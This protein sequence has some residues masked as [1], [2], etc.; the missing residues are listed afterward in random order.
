MNNCKTRQLIK[1]TFIVIIFS[2]FLLTFLSC[3]HLC[4]NP[5][6]RE[7]IILTQ[8][9]GM[10]IV[11]YIYGDEYHHR[12]ETEEGYTIILNKQTGTI[13]YAKLENNR[14]VPSG[15]ITGAVAP[16]YLQAIDYPKH[17]S[18]RKFK[19]AEIRRT[20]PERLHDFIS[21]KRS[22][23]NAF[24]T[25]A[26][27]GT[28]KV[29]VVCVEFQPE[30]SPPTQWHSGNYSPSGF[31]RRIFSDDPSDI[32]MT[33]YYKSNSYNKFWPV[34]HTYPDWVTLPQTASWYELSGNWT[35]IIE[36]AMDAIRNIDPAYDFTQY[37]NDGDLDLILIW[38]GT[39]QTWGD[40]YWPHKSSPF[41]NR[42]GV[43]IKYYNAVN[44][45]YSSGT[46]NT[47]IAVFCHEYG[48]MTGCPDLYDYSGFHNR[49]M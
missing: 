4:A 19:I 28:K 5:V 15:M 23:E 2:N 25:Q 46:E 38:A 40:F 26:L 20:N 43:R 42:H 31:D 34:G 32:S 21:S 44:E 24:K 12:I 8:P 39:R 47:G 1:K 33:N 14:L 41:L 7:K 11:G 45:R 17:L 30:D 9:N 22:S 37:A 36:N 48:H 18:D 3:S 16:S 29:F 27:E 10:K 35:Q 49:P 6:F 13:E